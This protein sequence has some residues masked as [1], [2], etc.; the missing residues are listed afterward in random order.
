[1]S[2]QTVLFG[3]AANVGQ[4]L[5]RLDPAGTS[6]VG[7]LDPHQ[8]R[9]HHVLVVG[10]NQFPQLLDGH[11]AV[12]AFD[13]ARRNAGQLGKGPL[14]VV[15]DVTL[16]IANQLVP[17]LAVQPHG[18]LVGHG[19]RGHEDRRFLAQ[20]LGATRLETLDRRVDVNHVIAHL[21]GRHRGPH[22][23]RGLGHRV[24]AQ[25]DGGWH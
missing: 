23:R 20:Q 17:R 16:D 8:P 22:P 11:H 13:G 9:P 10:A 3:P 21:G 25:V 14:L 18:D 1:M 6:I 15:V 5:V 12:S 19:P 24:A 7:V 2:P 4:I